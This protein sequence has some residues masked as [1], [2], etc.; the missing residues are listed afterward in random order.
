M[1]IACAGAYI[2]MKG[3]KIEFGC[4]GPLSV[5]SGGHGF[6]G[7]TG[8]EVNKPN[9]NKANDIDFYSERFQLKDQNTGKPLADVLYCIDKGDGQLL[10]GRTDARGYTM[11]VYS[12]KQEN[13]TLHW[14][15]DAELYLWERGRTTEV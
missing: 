5:K 3:G 13:I 10:T 14:G 7:P 15:R 9:Y 1:L 11:C 8:M 2:R 12:P 6:S 4:P